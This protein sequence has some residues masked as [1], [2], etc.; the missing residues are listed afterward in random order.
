M[1]KVSFDSIFKINEDGSLEA[2]QRTRIG[3]ATF[4]SGAK[5]RKGVSLSG[6]DFT[7]FI[8]HDFEVE[9]DGD[10]LVIKAIYGKRQQ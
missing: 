3:G 8:G 2:L 4:G 9:T 5:F 10:V 7:Q 1:P 6:V